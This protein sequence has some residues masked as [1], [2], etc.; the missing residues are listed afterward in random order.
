MR[1]ELD[2]DPIGLVGQVTCRPLVKVINNTTG[3][4]FYYLTILLFY[5]FII[6]VI[7]FL[8]FRYFSVFNDMNLFVEFCNGVFPS[9][10]SDEVSESSPRGGGVRYAQ[11]SEI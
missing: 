4:L 3:R 7:I 6:S 1:W 2:P 9:F 8:Y 10:W 11:C 5:Y